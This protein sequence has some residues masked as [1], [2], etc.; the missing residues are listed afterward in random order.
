MCMCIIYDYIYVHHSQMI[1]AFN[2]SAEP[3]WKKLESVGFRLAN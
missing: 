1:Y 2:N 3:H